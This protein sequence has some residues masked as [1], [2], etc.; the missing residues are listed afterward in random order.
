MYFESYKP[1]VVF[2]IACLIAVFGCI[3]WISKL[4]TEL[5]KTGVPIAVLVCISIPFISTT[6]YLQEFDYMNPLLNLMRCLTFFTASMMFA[7]VSIKFIQ[8]YKMESLQISKARYWMGIILT[9]FL[10][11]AFFALFVDVLLFLLR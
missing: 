11:I 10:S 8:W 6:I 2:A 9:T 4:K 3:Y 1:W 7:G 5:Q